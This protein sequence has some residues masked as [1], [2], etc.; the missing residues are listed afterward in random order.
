MSRC[1][2]SVGL[3]AVVSGNWRRQWLD[4]PVYAH[5]DT[6]AHMMN[7]SFRMS[8]HEYLYDLEDLT[9]RLTT[10]GFSRFAPVRGRVGYPLNFGAGA[11]PKF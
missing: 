8:G 11:S 7:A 9:L 3:S 6:A 1:R 4:D 5:I 10:A 2:T